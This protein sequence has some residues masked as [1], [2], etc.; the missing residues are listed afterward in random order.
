NYLTPRARKV[1]SLGC[2]ISIRNLM[3]EWTR[4]EEER[5]T[6]KTYRSSGWQGQ[7]FFGLRWNCG[8][9]TSDVI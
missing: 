2:P 1:N 9:W 4:E 7:V 5:R 6:P 8:S 3:H